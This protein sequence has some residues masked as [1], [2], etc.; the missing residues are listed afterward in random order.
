MLFNLLGYSG[1]GGLLGMCALIP[2]N[3]LISR[4]NVK[5]QKTLLVHRDARMRMMNEVCVTG[6]V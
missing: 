5:F 4:T 3:T 6:R 1:M 2:I